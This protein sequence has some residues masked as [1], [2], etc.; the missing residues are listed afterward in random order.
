[1][2]F[3]KMMAAGGGGDSAD[4]LNAVKG[5]KGLGGFVEIDNS[6]VKILLMAKCADSGTASKAS[7]KLNSLFKDAK[8]KTEEEISKSGKSGPEVDA[9]REVMSS[10]DAG[11]SG[12]LFEVSVKFRYGG[13][14]E[15]IKGLGA[16]GAGFGGGGGFGAPPTGVPPMGAPP[17]IPKGPA[18]GTFDPSKPAKEAGPAAGPKAGKKPK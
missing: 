17:V 1:M 14:K 12:E 18:K 8:K 4:I 2:D 7:D 9:Y 15:Q 11:N 10:F 3:I 5:A 16:M 13:L 6:K